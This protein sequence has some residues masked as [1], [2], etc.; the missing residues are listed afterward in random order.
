VPWQLHVC[1]ELNKKLSLYRRGTARRSMR[2]EILSTPAQLSLSSPSVQSFRKDGWNYRL[3]S[4]ADS[5]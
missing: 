5:I 1:N 4:L 3:R 2:V